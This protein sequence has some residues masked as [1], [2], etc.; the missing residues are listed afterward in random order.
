MG[1]LVA[2]IIAAVF[3]FIALQF[4]GQAKKASRRRR[5]SQT[6]QWVVFFFV[7]L[8][9]AIVFLVIAASLAIEQALS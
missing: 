1:P 8:L 3:A 9:G 5:D 7:C 4:Y 6:F 2:V